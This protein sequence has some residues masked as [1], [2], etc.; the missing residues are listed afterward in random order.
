MKKMLII[1]NDTPTNNELHKLL[2]PIERQIQEISENKSKSTMKMA[3]LNK[4]IDKLEEDC[5]SN[6]DKVEEQI[7]RIERQVGERVRTK[8]LKEALKI[9]LCIDEGKSYI[10]EL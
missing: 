7:A 8:E 5:N 6:E 3:Q 2:N 9:Y 1:L 10:R 4:K